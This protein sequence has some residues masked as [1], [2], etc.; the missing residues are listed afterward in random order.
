[1]TGFNIREDNHIYGSI[2][3]KFAGGSD[4]AIGITIVSYMLNIIF[5]QKN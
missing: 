1:M 2:L 5:I 4:D 3:L